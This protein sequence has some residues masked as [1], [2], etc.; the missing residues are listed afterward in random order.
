MWGVLFSTRLR[1]RCRVALTSVFLSRVK[2]PPGHLHSCP[3]SG[4]FS[5]TCLCWVSGSPGPLCSLFPW[6]HLSVLQRTRAPPAERLSGDA[7][8]WVCAFS[9]CTLSLWSHSLQQRLFIPADSSSLDSATAVVKFS[10]SSNSTCKFSGFSSFVT[11]VIRN[12]H[13]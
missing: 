5:V 13:G 7:W 4:Q 1:L 3:A 9:S 10:W 2:P 12:A 11:V 6:V 8:A